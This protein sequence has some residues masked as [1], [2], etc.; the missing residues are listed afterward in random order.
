[1]VN[2]LLAWPELVVLHLLSNMACSELVHKYQGCIRSVDIVTERG[3]ASLGFSWWMWTVEEEHIPA[4]SDGWWDILDLGMKGSSLAWIWFEKEEVKTTDAHFCRRLA[5]E[6][7]IT[8]TTRPVGKW[9]VEKEGWMDAGVVVCDAI[10]FWLS[11]SSTSCLYGLSVTASSWCNNLPY[12][13]LGQLQR[14]DPNGGATHLV[15][16]FSFFFNNQDLPTFHQ[17]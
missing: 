16:H 5:F 11:F 10:I 3:A 7:I 9:C 1:M 13:G 8:G 14:V 6:R 15:C 17:M 12:L 4:A 2:R